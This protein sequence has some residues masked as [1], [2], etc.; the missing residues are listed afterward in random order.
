M[1]ND[2]SLKSVF[3]Y[4][5][6]GPLNDSEFPTLPTVFATFVE[7]FPNSHP[8]GSAKN[9]SDLVTYANGEMKLSANK[10]ILSCDIK[11]WRNIFDPGSPDL[12][13]G[14]TPPDAFDHVNDGLTVTISVSD[15]GQVTHQRKKNGIPISIFPNTPSIPFPLNAVYENSLF[16][17][18]SEIGVRSLSFTLGTTFG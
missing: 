15:T 17:E 2:T 12:G 11:L 4:A 6:Q 16:V 7:H 18:K 3:D 13:S 10:K 5:K 9:A 1:A 14:S 8:S